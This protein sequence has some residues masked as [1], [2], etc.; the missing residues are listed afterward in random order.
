MHGDTASYPVADVTCEL[1]G[2]KKEV[3]VAVVP[4]L[5][6]DFL[7]GCDDHLSFAGVM[8]NSSSLPVMTRS[9]KLKQ[10]KVWL[11]VRGRRW[12]C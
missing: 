8:S 6:V 1:D 3:A 5:P 2:W 7:I 10:M 11:P 12:S 4:G 9:Q